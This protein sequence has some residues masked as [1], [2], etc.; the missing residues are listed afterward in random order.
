M[1]IGNIFRWAAVLL[2]LL[3]ASNQAM[4]QGAQW[5]L[6]HGEVLQV[7]PEEYKLLLACAEEQRLLGLTEDCRIF[8]EGEP[9]TLAS[10][11][12]V[13]PGAFQDALCWINPQG[14]VGLIL[15]NYWVVEEDGLLAS[16]DIFGNPK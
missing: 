4:A 13:G 3:L 2:I 7:F 16:Y 10:L 5:M 8:R 6:V 11:R 12:P 9:V 15:V 1:Y 14:L